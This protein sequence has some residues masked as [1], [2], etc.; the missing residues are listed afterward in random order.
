MHAL[1]FL[2]GKPLSILYQDILDTFYIAS[3][4]L[5]LSIFGPF[6]IKLFADIDPNHIGQVRLEDFIDRLEKFVNMSI[7][8]VKQG[9]KEPVR[10]F[11]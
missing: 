7:Q 4:Q 10:I 1:M 8:R 2:G 11:R 9:V 6:F 3:K 5:N